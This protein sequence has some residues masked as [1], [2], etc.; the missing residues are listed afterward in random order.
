MGVEALQSI[1]ITGFSGSTKGQ[2]P[3]TCLTTMWSH[4]KGLHI[5]AAKDAEIVL[6][7]EAA[8][9]RF[10]RSQESGKVVFFVCSSA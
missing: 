7:P 1:E 5:E 8:Q 6:A 10:R 2:K 9:G 4:Q 3:Q